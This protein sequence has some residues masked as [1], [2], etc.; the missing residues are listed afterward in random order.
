[1]KSLTNLCFK[2]VKSRPSNIDFN[3]IKFI[4]KLF[5]LKFAKIVSSQVLV[6]NIDES[7]INRGIM[8]NYSW[9]LKGVPI[10]SNYCIFSGSLSLITAICSNGAWLSFMLDETID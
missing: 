9:G 4:R 8:S 6:V 5:A 3:K 7:S 1:M 10:E 2:K